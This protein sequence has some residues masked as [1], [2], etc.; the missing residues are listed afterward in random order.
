M[1]AVA[2]Q[3]PARRAN[4]QNTEKPLEVRLSNIQA[5]KGKLN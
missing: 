3:A 4:F 1:A 5:A 2:Q